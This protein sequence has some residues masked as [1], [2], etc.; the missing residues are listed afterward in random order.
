MKNVKPYK[1]YEA[2]IAQELASLGI[3]PQLITQK[4]L[5]MYAEAQQLV[6]AETD[7]AGREYRMTAAT[8]QAWH[9]MKTAARQDNII[10]E[11]VSAFRSIER[12]IEIIQNKLDQALTI[13]KILTLSAPPGYS[14]HHTGCAIDINTPGCMPTEEEFE[15]TD[16]F[17]WLHENAAHFR[18]TLS[19]P[20]NNRLGFIYE[21]WH[22]CFQPEDIEKSAWRI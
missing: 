6:I 21:P 2:R 1:E 12:Q 5:P 14:E 16:A 22:W 13:E 10:L 4:R 11:V 18:F 3:S 17:A 9:A 7:I 8:A 19:Y 20:R 15:H